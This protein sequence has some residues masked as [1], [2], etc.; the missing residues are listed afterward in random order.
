MASGRRSK[1]RRNSGQGRHSTLKDHVQ[2]GK[3]FQAPMN[4]VGPMTH[5]PWLKDVLPSLLWLCA[6]VSAHGVVQGMTVAATVMDRIWPFIP[7]KE[8][9]QTRPSAIFDGSLQSFDLV[10]V[11]DRQRA[12]AA[13]K[14]DGLYEKGFPWLLVRALSKYTDAP[15]SWVLSAW[16]GNEQIV[17]ADEPEEFLAKVVADAWH[18]QSEVATAAKMIYFRAYLKAGLMRFTPQIRWPEMLP[19]YPDNLSAEDR[20]YVEGSVR[21]TFQALW[22]GLPDEA[23]DAVGWGPSFWRQNWQLYRCTTDPDPIAAEASA[24]TDEPPWEAARRHW[25]EAL[26]S[27]EERFLAAYR[28]AD[29]DLY[30]PD[31]NEVLT[32]MTYRHLRAIDTMVRD[33]RLWTV[34]HGSGIV[35]GVVEARIV[36]K[37]LIKKNDDALYT[38]F[39]DYGRGHLKLQ[40][41]HLREYRDSLTEP[42]EGLDE[43]IESMEALV[44]RDLME[45]FQDISVEGNFAGSDLRKMA[46]AV[47]LEREYRLVFAPMSANVHGEWMALERYALV[48]CRNPLHRGHRI[49]NPQRTLQLGPELVDLALDTL[50]AMIDE[51]IAAISV[52]ATA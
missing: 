25:V 20:A 39:K 41:L 9:G 19:K 5:V 48:P 46:Y 52:P 10:P 24:T 43:V 21:A 18:G 17:A 30:S 49:P 6:V 45:E 14:A 42:P 16:D 51:Y 8:E 26:E 32:G 44:N 11:A 40:V 12:L 34:E 38:R 36:Q 4:T 3:T 50:A 15:G 35:R 28:T 27:E 33:P 22:A 2:Q 1:K 47:G 13:L 37:W 23:P 7:T 29:P 31:R